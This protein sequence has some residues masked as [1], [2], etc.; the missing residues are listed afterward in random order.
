M[1][2]ILAI[3][4][5]ISMRGTC[6]IVN[7]T[8]LSTM[9]G[10]IMSGG[11]DIYDGDD[12]W[13][14]VP[15]RSVEV[16][17]PSTGE[18]CFLPSLPD[19]RLSHTMDKL[20]ICGG[21]DTPKT[22]LSFTS[23]KWVTSNNL[24]EERDGH[25][26]WQTEEGL[27]VLGGLWSPDTSEIVDLAGEQGGPSFNL[28]YS[29]AASCSMPDPT[30]NSV[31]VTGGYTQSGYNYDRVVRYG[32][33]GF[34][35]DLPRLNVGRYSHGCGTYNRGDGQMV[36]LVVGGFDSQSSSLSSTEV[37]N[38]DSEAWIVTTPLPNALYGEVRGTTVG[39]NIYMTGG[40][41]DS[42]YCMDYIL[43]WLEEEQKWEE[44]GKM[45]NG[46]CGHAVTTIQMNDPAME[47]CGSDVQ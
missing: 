46:R 47:H 32:V 25:C 8:N 21:N 34:V 14:E 29:A 16:F 28:Q 38:M 19:D 35:E 39:Q 4:L 42:D 37:L 30:S 1:I 12:D 31:I 18:S 2:S 27:L 6:L 44:T 17:I 9:E 26:S 22:C 23:G 45:K 3:L 41:S 13:D 36:F 40:S 43:V 10:I 5:F 7:M 15:D 11:E 33:L 24:V 20:T